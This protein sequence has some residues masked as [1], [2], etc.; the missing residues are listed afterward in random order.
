MKNRGRAL[1]GAGTTTTWRAVAW[2]MLAALMLL[3][4]A[5][6]AHADAGGQIA[7]G[8]NGTSSSGTLLANQRASSENLLINLANEG[9]SGMFQNFFLSWTDPAGK[10]FS[11]EIDKTEAAIVSV[12]LGAGKTVNFSCGSPPSAFFWQVVK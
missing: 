8:T 1:P 10:P 4:R 7:C 3:W 9:S 12:S 11:I 2:L 6:P 5:G